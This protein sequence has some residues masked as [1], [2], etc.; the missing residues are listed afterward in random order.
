MGISFSILD[1]FLEVAQVMSHLRVGGGAVVSE[2]D[3]FSSPPGISSEVERAGRTDGGKS[4]VA[5]Q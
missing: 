4:G 3:L 1:L 5:W 2:V